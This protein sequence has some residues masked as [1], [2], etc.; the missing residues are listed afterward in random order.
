MVSSFVVS[1][2]LCFAYMKAMD[3]CAAVLSWLSVVLFQLSLIGLAVLS[4]F[5]K[6][7]RAL[8]GRDTTFFECLFW[9]SCIF[10]VL[11]LV[12]LTW[13]CKSMKIS[14]AVIDTASDFVIDTKRGLLIPLLYFTVI[15]V[16]GMFWLYSFIGVCSIG[17][18]TADNYSLQ[19]KHVERGSTDRFMIFGM[20][21]GLVWIV[22]FLSA[23]SQFSIICTSV[24]WYFSNKN[25]PGDGGP[26]G[27]S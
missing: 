18:I 3:C 2:A 13:N 7:E 21:F 14:I 23:A 8:D 10:A 27:E 9:L 22:E 5:Q 11:F 17:T 1:I 4:Y 15:I 25:E 24:S 16:F 12:F 6:S 26:P 19:L 20:L